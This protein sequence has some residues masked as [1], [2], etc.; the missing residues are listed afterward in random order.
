[1]VLTQDSD[2]PAQDR[3]KSFTHQEPPVKDIDSSNPATWRVPSPLMMSALVLFGRGSWLSIA[4]DFVSKMPPNITDGARIYENSSW[5]L[6]CRGMPFA[7][8]EQLF[9]AG[10]STSDDFVSLCSSVDQRMFGGYEARE[11]DV[12]QATHHLLAAFAPVNQ[13]SGSQERT[14]EK[15]ENL[16]EVS[17]FVA[18]RAFLTLYSPDVGDQEMA[19]GGSLPVREI[20]ASP[21][22]A[23]QRPVLSNRT[24]IILSVLIGV[25]LLGLSYITSYMYRVPTWSDQLDAM[26]MAQIGASLHDRDVLPAIGP[27]S[28]DDIATLQ[29]VGGLI[30]IV[31]KCP[32]P[33]RSTIRSVSDPIVTDGSD[34]E[35]QR[36]HLAEEGRE[37]FGDSTHREISMIGSVSPDLDITGD[38]EPAEGGRESSEDG[39]SG[40]MSPTL[41]TTNS[42]DAE[43]QRLNPT[44]EL[45][46]SF[47]GFSTGVELG[48]DAPGPI[49]TTDVPRRGPY[50]RGM[51]R[52]WRAFQST[53]R[54]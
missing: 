33:N 53:K 19:K 29:T 26:A 2:Y 12:L 24:V 43:S 17:M 4:A 37:S 35:L 45:R 16:L 6:F 25:Q 51:R 40:A 52:V 5:Q 18:N 47:E 8:L 42:S 20:Y 21:G 46:G 27:V 54:P 38:S 23:V 31:K 39:S 15:A 1:M 36:L 30:G 41:A 14:L 50:V 48:L 49:L 22:L 7:K 3:D 10:G 32:R 44:E 34:A 9:P 28:K 11:D 13:W